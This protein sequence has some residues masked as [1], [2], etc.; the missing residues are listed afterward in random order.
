[1]ITGRVAIITSTLDPASMNIRE[2]LLSNYSFE[3]TSE[4]AFG[5]EVWEVEDIKLITIDCQLV[6]ADFLEK[7][8]DFE[9]FIF[10]SRHESLARLP[11]LLVHATGNFTDEVKLGGKP[12]K[13]SISSPISMLTALKQLVESKAVLN[14]DN[15]EVSYEA[16]HHGPYLRKTAVVFVEIGS[17]Y[18]EWRNRTAGIAAASAI[19]AAAMENKEKDVCIAFGGPHYAPKITRE[20]LKR[21][22]PVGHIAPKYVLDYIDIEM[23]RQMVERTRGIVKYALLDWKGMKKKHRDRLLPILEK[24]KLK[25]IRI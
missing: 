23:V 12:R 7:E 24:L 6:K 2:I 3:K 11:S 18:E 4:K 9:V 14:L 17:G 5:R 20:V 25:V 21:D 13:L 15:W 19:M 22:L 1:M 10:A 8:L 16:T